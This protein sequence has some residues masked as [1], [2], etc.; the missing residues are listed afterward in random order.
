[1][2]LSEDSYLVTCQR[3]ARWSQVV[4]S[5]VAQ[6]SAMGGRGRPSVSRSVRIERSGGL[7]CGLRY[8]IDTTSTA[9]RSAGWG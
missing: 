5:A 7:R 3:K 4:C 2:I 8:A 9:K 6:K 1:M